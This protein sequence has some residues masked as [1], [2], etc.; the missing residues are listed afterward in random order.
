[1]PVKD[2]SARL[3][4]LALALVRGYSAA[5]TQTGDCVRWRIFVT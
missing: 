4:Q 1:M 3:K 5:V 2:A